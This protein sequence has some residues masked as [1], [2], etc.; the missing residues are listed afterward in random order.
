MK[1]ILDGNIHF[2]DGEQQLEPAISDFW[3]WAMSRLMADGPRGD[4]A[5]FIVN[6]ALGSDLTIPKRGWG[7]HDID[8]RGMGIEVKC[9]SVLQEWVRSTPSKPIWGCAKTMSC[10]VELQ[11]DEYIYV[12]RKPGDFP[13]RRSDVY[14]FCLFNEPDREKADPADFSQWQFYIVPTAVLNERLGDQRQIS[15]Q[16]L[17]RIEALQCNYS[18]LK[19]TIDAVIDKISTAK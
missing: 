15:L 1:K 6:T 5:E 3:A 18:K 17:E 14:V 12:G 4:L 13:R 2:K 9:S 8:Y 7:E 10:D 11:G 16:G 19:A